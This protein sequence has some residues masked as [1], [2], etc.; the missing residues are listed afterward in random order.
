MYFDYNLSKSKS[1]IE[2]ECIEIVII[3]KMRDNEDSLIE[4]KVRKINEE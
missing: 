2:A 4:L 3:Y 1:I